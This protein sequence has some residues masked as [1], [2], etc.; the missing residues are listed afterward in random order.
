MKNPLKNSVL[1]IFFKQ[2]IIVIYCY[3]LLY[4]VILMSGST[5]LIKEETRNLLKE[6]GKKY[7]TY[8]D[9]INK[10]ILATDKKIFFEDQKRILATEKFTNVDNL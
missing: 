2:N 4:L 7:D 5:I 1:F 8:D 10:L 9:I 6:F 3:V